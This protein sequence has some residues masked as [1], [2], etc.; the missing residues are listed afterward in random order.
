MISTLLELAGFACLVAAAFLVSTLVGLLAAGGSLLVLGYAL[1]GV[2]V[3]F[4]RRRAS[5]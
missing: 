1:D 3:R 5:T 2:T 4:P